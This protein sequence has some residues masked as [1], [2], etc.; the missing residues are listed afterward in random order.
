MTHKKYCCDCGHYIPGGV[1]HNCDIK[2]KAND[3]SVC[4]IQEACGEYIDREVKQKEVFA[5]I[6]MRRL[7]KRRTS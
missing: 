6:Q 1:E 7:K 2:V 4:A 5:P 3:R